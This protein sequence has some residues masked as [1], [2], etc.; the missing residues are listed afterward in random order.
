MN[1]KTKLLIFFGILLAIVA[2]FCIIII[3]MKSEV[4]PDIYAISNSGKRAIAVK[5]GYDWN[6][7]NGT[8][9]TDSIALQD[10]EYKNENMLLALPGEKITLRN[11]EETNRGHKFYQESFKY[12]DKANNEVTIPASEDA[13][14]KESRFLDFNA[15]ETEGTYI[16]HFN[17]NYYKKGTVTYA[18]KVVVSSAPTYD[19]NE[20]IKYKNTKIS[21]SEA[22]G[23]ILKKLPYSKDM[24]GYG[25]RVATEP[26]ELILN[27]GELSTAKVALENTSIALFTLID[28]LGIITYKTSDETYMHSRDEIENIVGRQLIEYAN[29]KDLWEKEVLF[30]EKEERKNSYIDI[31]KAIMSDILSE[32]IVDETITVAIDLDTFEQ[33]ELIKLNNVE[34]R[35]LLEFCME[36]IDVIYECSYEHFNGNA[37][38]VR[39]LELT[40]DEQKYTLKIAI[41]NGKNVTE[42]LYIANHLENKWNVEEI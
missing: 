29:D 4:V 5:M 24:K 31:Y 40:S 9:T 20:L 17:L 18:L 6:S 36:D 2:A 41:E 39:C 26:Y 28:E 30:K 21:N 3:S 32:L 12:Y 22:I 23:S 38:L 13:L 1:R 42:K 10:V 34:R 19:V 8:M 14:Y 15:P 37:T 11:S 27:Y 33:N 35:E 7:Y 16:Y 25:A